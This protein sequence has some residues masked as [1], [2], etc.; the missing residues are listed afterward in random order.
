MMKRAWMRPY[1][2]RADDS[3]CSRC[4]SLRSSSAAERRE[5]SAC[6]WRE[7]EGRG[8]TRRVGDQ[9]ERSRVALHL[10]VEARQVEAVEDVLL[11][12]LAEVLVALGREEP[13]ARERTRVS[14][15]S[16]Y[17]ADD[18]AR[19]PAAWAP[20]ATRTV[21]ARERRTYEIHE[22]AY[23]ADDESDRSSATAGAGGESQLACSVSSMR[24]LPSP[25]PCCYRSSP[26]P[27]SP[28]LISSS[29]PDLPPGPSPYSCTRH[30]SSSCYR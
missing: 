15:G 29:Q 26:S 17:Y 7:W 20:R 5:V 1:R 6:G 3:R 25:H 4:S 16:A 2:C 30:L 12:D 14:G 19:N 18:E 9:V 28:G 24:G 13:P 10:G 23:D 11:V 22:L 21:V 27:P 8:R